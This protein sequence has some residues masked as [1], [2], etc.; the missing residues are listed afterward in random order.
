M[1]NNKRFQSI[2]LRRKNESGFD[3]RPKL[4]APPASKLP[5][6]P[7]EWLENRNDFCKQ[8]ENIYYGKDDNGVLRQFTYS[9]NCYDY[10]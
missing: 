8:C 5:L 6:P 9:C 2:D 4:K 1:E 3:A 10:V 7:K